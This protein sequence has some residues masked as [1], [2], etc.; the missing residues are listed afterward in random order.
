M[1]YTHFSML[2]VAGDI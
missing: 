2:T 1:H